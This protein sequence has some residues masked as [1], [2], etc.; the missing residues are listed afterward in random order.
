MKYFIYN[1]RF[2]SLIHISIS[3]KINNI[4]N[5]TVS[6]YT[7][8]LSESVLIEKRKDAKAMV[9]SGKLTQSEF[10]HI[11]DRDKSDNNKFTGWIAKQFINSDASIDEISSTVEEWESF[12]KRRKTAHSD[13]YMYKTYD[14]LVSE[15]DMLNSTGDTLSSRELEKSYNIVLDNDDLLIANPHTHE[16]SRKLGLSMFAYRK[17]DDG[18]D[19]A[20]CTTYKSPNHFNDY[21]FQ[22]NVT[23]Y[24]VK[25]KPGSRAEKDLRAEG[26]DP[27]AMVSAVAVYPPKLQSAARERDMP[28]YEIY[29]GKDELIRDGRA[30]TYMDIL[31][32]YW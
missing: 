15:V 26:F 24:Y 5:Q 23:F 20:W 4:Y 12:S 6:R 19:S 28:T 16:A 1:H 29:D 30:T 3:M 9:T 17:C 18:V 32:K 8:S 27:A 22:E 11:L 14:D 31:S 10:E 13:L 2:L 7:N 21:Y 25:V